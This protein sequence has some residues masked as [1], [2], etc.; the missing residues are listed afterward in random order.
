M[1]SGMNLAVFSISRLR[2]EAEAAAGN[3]DA[4]RLLAMRQ[5]SNFLL[6]TIL[7]GN[8]G[9]NVLLTLLSDSV[10]AGLLAF[11]FSTFVITFAG[12]IIPQA[13]FSRH[14]LRMAALLGPVLRIYQFVLY[15]VAKPAALMLDKWLGVEGVQ[16]FRERD[17]RE[18]IK[19]H[20]EAGETDM[21]KVEGIGALNFL[22]LDDLSAIQEGVPIDPLSIVT[23]S[24]SAQG[25]PIFP[26]FN[27]DINDPFIEQVHRSGRKWVVLADLKGTPQLVLDAD[28]FVR[29]ALFQDKFFHAHTY[30]HR[31][32]IVTDKN[33]RL[34][35]IIQ[36]L[37]VVKE[38]P[39]DDDVIDQDIILVWGDE[40]RIITG[41]DILGRLMRG[42]TQ[43]KTQ[44]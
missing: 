28:G 22:A 24:F 16:Y 3:K 39:D 13:Y 14:A 41:A 31:P 23:V 38:Q 30:C 33:M 19:M 7:W 40:K 27:G 8:V 1:F 34:G 17:L 25:L 5:D 11:L 29:H 35:K 12:E 18:V 6:T 36:N 15:L 44:H 21:G 43:V 26:K 20:M 4:R 9:I 10:M 37:H 42:I 2:L 32:V